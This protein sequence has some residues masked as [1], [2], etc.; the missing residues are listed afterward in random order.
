MKL[1]KWLQIKICGI[2]IWPIIKWFK[3]NKSTAKFQT[4]KK[5]A[6]FD[7]QGR[8]LKMAKYMVNVPDPPEVFFPFDMREV[9]SL[10]PIDANDRLGCCVVAGAAHYIT[11][12]HLRI[13]Q[14][15]IPTESE[16]IKIYRKLSGCKDSGL[17]MLDFMKY[18]HK[19]PLFGHKIEAFGRVD[20]KNEKLVKQ[21]IQLFG[22][23]D[24]GFL[25]QN[26]AIKD[27]ES[28]TPWTP[29]PNDGGGHCV[30]A[31]AYDKDYYYIL[32]WGGIIR[33][34]KA[35]WLAQIDEAFAILPPEYKEPG[36]APGFDSETLLNDYNAV[37]K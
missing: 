30:I 2:D 27:F 22:G 14:I 29:G 17:V 32:T 37:T 18:W 33:A 9:A 25:V 3:K 12:E 13:G 8:T 10:F 16:V 7:P 28:G 19:N 24:L 20:Y 21:C 6:K 15:L 35:W 26:D 11:N 5:A 34:T 4:G 31:A 1:L 36:F 23:I